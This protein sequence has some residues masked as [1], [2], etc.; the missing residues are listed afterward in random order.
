MRLWMFICEHGFLICEDPRVWR[1]TNSSFTCILAS[2]S[3]CTRTVK[4][5]VNKYHNRDFSTRDRVLN[6]FLPSVLKDFFVDLFGWTSIR[7][8]SNLSNACVDECERVT[9]ENPGYDLSKLCSSVLIPSSDTWYLTLKG[10]VLWLTG[11]TPSLDTGTRTI[12]RWGWYGFCLCPDFGLLEVW[13]V[14]L[15]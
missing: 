5:H 6:S 4:V 2:T 11:K 3:V 7:R 14:F 1:E 15:H 12:V 8:S 13:C 9:R 10:E